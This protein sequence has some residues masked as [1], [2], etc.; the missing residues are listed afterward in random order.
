M[1]T[2]KKNWGFVFALTLFSLFFAYF[3]FQ[4][5]Q[6]TKKLETATNQMAPVVRFKMPNGE[7]SSSEEH[8]GK[9]LLINFWAFWCQPC[10]EEM[11]SLR[12]IEEKFRSKGLEIF[13]IH[14][15][16][17]NYDALKRLPVKTYPKNLIYDFSK[18]SLEEYGVSQ[19][20]YS[21]LIDREGKLVKTFLG[22]Y[23]WD[24]PRMLSLI[25]KLL[26]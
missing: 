5:K 25:E 16:E 6:K 17:P 10:L 23:P 12:L 21:V 24:D 9:V 18:D 1:N 13:A 7:W 26:K 8:K 20:P 2:I 22:S 19:L 14:A 4:T 11:P 3:I 15:D